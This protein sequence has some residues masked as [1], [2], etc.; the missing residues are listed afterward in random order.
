MRYKSQQQT[1]EQYQN[2]GQSSLGYDV[3]VDGRH[4]NDSL[5]K[6][7]LGHETNVKVQYLLPTKFELHN[8]LA[9]IISQ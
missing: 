1:P 5:C 4:R 2:S 7:T 6:T 9:L 8:I 3:G